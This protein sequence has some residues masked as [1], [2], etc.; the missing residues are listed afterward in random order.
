MDSPSGGLRERL[1]D[2]GAQENGSKMERGVAAGP[3]G[4]E[5]LTVD[6]ML[7]KYVGEFGRAQFWH[8]VLVSLAW[9]V[10]ALHTMSMIF[11][12]RVPDWRCVDQGDGGG[13]CSPSSSLCD[14]APG[15]WEWVDGKS[16]STVSQFNLICG[17]EYKVG[18]AGS[19]FFIGALFGAGTY[20]SLSDSLLGRKGTLAMCCMLTV[21]LGMLTSLV[22]NYWLYAAARFVTGLNSSG[23]GLCCF[24]L[25]TEIV[26]PNRRGAVGM[27]AFYFFSLGIMILP[28]FDIF[29]GSWRELYFM[30]SIPGALYCVLV[31]PFMWES[32]RWYLVKGR[33]ADAMK[34]LRAFAKR[35]GNV[36][37]EN[38]YLI[39]HT[40]E[41]ADDD[42]EGRAD[43][44]PA[45]PLS[46]STLH[47]GKEYRS[48]ESCAV[49]VSPRIAMRSD[50]GAS[51]LDG[52]AFNAAS[53]PDEKRI[54]ESS[55]EFGGTL[56]DVFR[57]GETRWRMILMVCIWFFIGVCYYGISL[58]VVNLGFNLHI[59][60]F[61]NGL[62][63]LPVYTL[64][65]VL[66]G[67]LGR[68]FMLVAALSSA[69]LCCL[70]GSFAFGNVPNNSSSV[71]SDSLD[72]KRVF[73]GGGGSSD[74]SALLRLFCG[75]VGIFGTAG[76]Y[77]L[78]YIYTME[79]FPT[80]VRNA[81]L[82][83]A[84]QA[85]S[86]GSVVA[87]VVAVIGRSSPSLPFVVFGF[88]SIVGAVLAT[89]LPETKNQGLHETMEGMERTESVKIASAAAAASAGNGNG[90]SVQSS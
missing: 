57:Y 77:N 16:A 10:E 13:S 85:G 75:I 19:L 31:L 6:E 50:S 25:G 29:T 26:G 38:A 49:V 87:P 65:A 18:L 82:G 24:V 48:G 89:R 21:A 90:N 61:L 1:L 28:L 53:L 14:L 86:I 15:S 43:L 54:E 9:T 56:L 32:P 69:G 42:V 35:N 22:P 8:F 44:N 71:D 66:L 62:V 40:L 30:T 7:V 74:Y 80:V 36:V 72:L 46:I 2:D 51:I 33:T 88:L 52:G 5:Y 73:S 60:V 55:S 59:S 47:R 76:A 41:D 78:V 39:A 79:L 81:A 58:N 4:R 37:P 20:G 23:I 45:S 27:S 84:T 11:G 67:R 63:E 12:D 34:V 3:E 17:E 68:K 83:L 70:A 64:T